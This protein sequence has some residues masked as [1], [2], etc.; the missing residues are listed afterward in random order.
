MN[1]P[2]FVHLHNHSFYSLLDGLSSPYKLAEAAAELVGRIYLKKDVNLFG[3]I[4]YPFDL[5]QGKAEGDLLYKIGL[6]VRF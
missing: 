3:R 4:E 5:N 2:N 6:Q 1:E